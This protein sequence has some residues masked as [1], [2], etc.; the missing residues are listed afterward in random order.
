LIFVGSII[1]WG[2]VTNPFA[3]WLSWQ[4]FFMG[5]IGGKSG[6]WAYANVGVILALIVGFFGHIGLSRQAIGRQ[7]NR[8]LPLNNTKSAGTLLP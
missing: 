4:G 7:E 6:P 5:A 3:S 8:P 1:G 2:F